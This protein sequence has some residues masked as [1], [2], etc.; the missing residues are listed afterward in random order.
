MFMAAKRGSLVLASFIVLSA[1]LT[2]NHA[3]ASAQSSSPVN[4]PAIPQQ[5][6]QATQ[7][8]QPQAV[9]TTVPDIPEEVPEEELAPAALEIDV[10]KQ[11]PLLQTLYKATRETKE[12]EILARLAEAKA[13]INS[14]TDLKAIDPQGR[15]AL[16]WVV[17]GSS[18]SNKASVTVAY[19]ELADAMI[20]RGIDI[21]HQD[22][23]QDTALDYMLYSPSFEMQTLLME[24]GATSG[25]LVATFRFFDEMQMQSPASDVPKAISLSRRADL[26][27]GATLSVRLT[28]PV[29]SDRSRTGDPVEGVVTYPLCKDGE[30]MVCK[31]GELVVAPGTKVNGTVLFATKAPDKYSR[32]RLV[33]DF[34]NIVHKDGQL[35]PLYAR[36]LDVDNARETVRNNEILGII[37]PHAPKKASLVFAGISAVNP[38]AGYAIKGVQTVYG[39]SVRREILFPATTD[40]QVQVVRPSMLKQKESWSGWPQ[41]EMDPELQSIVQNAPLRTSAANKT[42]SDLTNLIFLGSKERLTSSFTES[43]WIEADD[44]G[45]KAALKVAQATMRNT[46]YTSAPVSILL[47]NGQPPD[48]VFQKS[49]NTFA[50][51][52]HI[53]IWKLKKTYKGQDVWIGAATHDIAT[54]NARGYTK[55]T[56]RIDPHVDRERDWIQ[57]DLLFSGMAVA[58][59]DIERPQAPKK[60]ANATGDDIV[61]DGKIT[62]VD[63]GVSRSPQ[64]TPALVP[65]SSGKL[66]APAPQ[67]QSRVP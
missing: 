28:S 31:D 19:E 36:V 55:W 64:Q 29:Y 59:A 48:L 66:E 43:H 42:P 62:V 47:L 23:Y 45:V 58:S 6:P 27:P 21:N 14:G 33:L 53:R 30:K 56:H 34:S 44:L 40:L 11:S 9:E 26:S 46:G 24:S 65:R 39:L 7:D 3:P 32:P 10:S 50:K 38:F 67:V 15:T 35:S 20:Q 5:E 13:L 52:H 51:R 12:K 49:L 18:Y 2:I 63:L 16:H 1:I 37:Q 4:G 25:F 57:S 60:A 54:E 41:L 22:I 17:F 61:T 8:S